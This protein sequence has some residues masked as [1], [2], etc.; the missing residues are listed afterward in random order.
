MFGP[1]ECRNLTV[2]GRRTSMRLEPMLWELL[3]H[4]ARRESTTLNVLASNIEKRMEQRVADGLN[5]TATVRLFV[6]GYFKAAATEEGHRQA[7]HGVGDPFAS[8]DM[9][10]KAKQER[11]RG[12]KP[13]AAIDSAVALAA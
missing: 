10:P 2:N 6:M 8:L 4:I 1:L 9:H 3:E 11:R 5:L 12:R 13:K 7:G